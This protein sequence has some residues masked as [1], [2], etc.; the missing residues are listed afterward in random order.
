M[1]DFGKLNFVNVGPGGTFRASGA[2]RTTPEDVDAIFEHLR[3][4]DTRKLVLYFHG[5][6][7]PESAGMATA[8]KM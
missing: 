1:A 3:A 6:L 8:E 2:V 5:G 7:V 4:A